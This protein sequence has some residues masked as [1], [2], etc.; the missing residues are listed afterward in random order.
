MSDDYFDFSTADKGYKTIILGGN[1]GSGKS[2]A[3]WIDK[4][5]QT[6]LKVLGIDM[7]DRV[8]NLKSTYKEWGK[9]CGTHVCLKLHATTLPLMLS[10]KVK[11]SLKPRE[12][13]A[14]KKESKSRKIVTVDFQGTVQE[15]LKTNNK[16]INELS[17]NRD[18]YGAIVF[19]GISAIRT[20]SIIDWLIKNAKDR[21]RP[22]TAGDWAQINDPVK[23]VI[24][25]FF[26]IGKLFKITTMITARMEDVYP[27]KGTK[28]YDPIEDSEKVIKSDAETLSAIAEQIALNRPL[29]KSLSHDADYLIEFVLNK[30]SQDEEHEFKAHVLKSPEGIYWINDLNDKWFWDEFVKATLARRKDIKEKQITPYLKKKSKGGRRNK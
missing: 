10:K 9:L 6:G 19:D 15:I 2:R 30:G 1:F 22:V 11:Q 18:E 4:A 21:T 8:D 27:K 23:K 7:E 29:Q 25:G 5:R 13:V 28:I 16:L 20:Y 24:N 14:L 3:A 26:Y 17:D 12:L